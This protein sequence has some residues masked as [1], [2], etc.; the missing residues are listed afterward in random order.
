METE[1]VKRF[2]QLVLQG[3]AH[4]PHVMFLKNLVFIQNQ[5]NICFTNLS[6][7][8]LLLSIFFR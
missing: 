3:R 7:L 6:T 5:D 2:N 1:D 8:A 4:K